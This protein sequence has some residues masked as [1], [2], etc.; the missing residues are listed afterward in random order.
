M[1]DDMTIAMQSCILSR[2][3]N[4]SPANTSMVTYGNAPLAARI[5]DP[6]WRP[7]KQGRHGDYS[8]VGVVPLRHIIRNGASIFR[9]LA[10][11]AEMNSRPIAER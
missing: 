4:I 1:W 2:W 10:P 3:D 7:S 11:T 8:A 6:G 9:D 5:F